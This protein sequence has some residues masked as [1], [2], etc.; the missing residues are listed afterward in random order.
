MACARNGWQVG[1]LAVQALP[2]KP[3]EGHGLYPVGV[4]AQLLRGADGLIGPLRP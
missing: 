1:R 4:E 3:G 2:G